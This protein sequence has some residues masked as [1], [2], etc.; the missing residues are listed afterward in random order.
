MKANESHFQTKTE[1]FAC[2]FS[3]KAML[4]EFFRQKEITPKGK[5]KCKKEEQQKR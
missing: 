2:K 4:K 1:N 3:L 5:W